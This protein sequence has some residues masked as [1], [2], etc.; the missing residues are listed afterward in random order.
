MTHFFDFV[1]AIHH[2]LI[3][4]GRLLLVFDKH[5]KDFVLEPEEVSLLLQSLILL[6][7]LAKNTLNTL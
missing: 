6:Y 7:I 2:P 1:K 5:Q 3:E 4:D